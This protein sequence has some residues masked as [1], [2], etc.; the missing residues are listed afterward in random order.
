MPRVEASGLGQCHQGGVHQASSQTSSQRPRRLL[1][2]S[3]PWKAG[4]CL[5]GLDWGVDRSGDPAGHGQGRLEARDLPVPA[6]DAVG[7]VIP[8]RPKAEEGP[9]DRE[10]QNPGCGARGPPAQLGGPALGGP[11]P[12][13]VSEGLSYS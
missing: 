6:A 1:P 4:G 13:Q 2:A 12:G 7:A 9:P 8:Q 3:P 11:D 10:G 5:A